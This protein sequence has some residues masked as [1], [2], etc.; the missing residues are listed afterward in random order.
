MYCSRCDKRIKENLVYYHAQLKSNDP[1][2][3]NGSQC[4]DYYWCHACYSDVSREKGDAIHVEDEDVL[5]NSILK[6]KNDDIQEEGWVQC[7]SC[8]S[9]VHQICGLFNRLLNDDN[10]THYQCPQCL[11]K[12]L[13][14][15]SRTPIVSRPNSMLEVRASFCI[16]A[17]WSC[18]A[19]Q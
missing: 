16:T 17:P 11:L 15:N 12:G 7:D 9:W 14:N 2:M 3:P 1:L 13:E 19:K 18:K 4:K 6:K 5:K 8:D 10:N